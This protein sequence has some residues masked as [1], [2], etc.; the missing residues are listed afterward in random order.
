M[1]KFQ[2]VIQ[3]E[4]QDQFYDICESGSVEAIR[5][6]ID[7]GMN[8]NYIYEYGSTVLM[9]AAR[10]NTPEAVRVLLNAGAD[11]SLIHI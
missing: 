2:K 1:A 10:F 6:A 8:V 11:L 7:S 5:E 9:G 3:Q 4:K